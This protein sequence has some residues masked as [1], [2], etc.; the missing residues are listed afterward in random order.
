MAEEILRLRHDKLEW[1]EAENEVIAIDMTRDVYLSANASA[2]LLWQR[3]REGATETSLVAQLV[4]EFGIDESQ[5][6]QDVAA[7]VASLREHGLLESPRSEP[8]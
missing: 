4:E 6:A 8:G 3:L 1:L 5:A 7:F 2:S